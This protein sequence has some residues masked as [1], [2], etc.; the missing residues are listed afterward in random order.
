M[1]NILIIEKTLA[2]THSALS[3]LQPCEMNIMNVTGVDIA[4]F[5]PIFN[6]SSPRG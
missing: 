3:T 1:Q 4:S 6:D 5:L 2:V